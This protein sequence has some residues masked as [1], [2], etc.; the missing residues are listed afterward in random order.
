MSWLKDVV[1]K[2]TSYAVNPFLGQL[3]VGLDLFGKGGG[4]APGAPDS[5]L[6]ESHIKSMGLQDQITQQLLDQQKDAAPLIREQMRFGLDSSKKAYD[7]SQEDR[8]WMLTR[9]GN[10]SGLQDRMVAD[11]NNFNTEARR[12]A[13]AAEAGADVA[14][15]FDAQ[16]RQM[17]RDM[18]RRG[19][20]P[21]SGA[22][23]A[24]R[25]AAALEQAKASAGAQNN[26]RR[27]ARQ[28]GFAM[29]DR[30]SNA[31]SG[32]P[33]MSAGM[34][35]AGAGFGTG[36][37]GVANA[38]AA[39][40]NSGLTAAGSLAGAMGANATGM[41]GAQSNFNLGG[42]KLN[43]QSDMNNNALWGQLG[44]AGMYAAMAYSDAKMKHRVRGLQRG[45]ALA[46]IEDIEPGKE[47]QYSDDS[48]S[49]DGGK[50][51][52]GP[53]AQDVQRVAGDA[54]APGGEMIDLVSLNGINMAATK[55]LSDELRDVK[56]EVRRLT[57]RR[58]GLRKEA[59]HA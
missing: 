32:Y 8:K 19:V 16:Q 23:T 54:V 7:Q 31:L 33:A 26:A 55:D 27:A 48:P 22:A 53:M 56:R 1:D 43:M 14:T 2:G 4:E 30:A 17:Q 42:A 6:I 25:T 38:G 40:M 44:Q 35:G 47:W 21:N 52:I 45:E 59:S 28:E 50:R 36:A 5:R 13:L 49:A 41:Y 24:M 34:T 3:D 12:E 39:G 46:M 11:A 57:A 9:R 37:V 15:A 51:H 10:L 58:G 20:N 29:T 18:E